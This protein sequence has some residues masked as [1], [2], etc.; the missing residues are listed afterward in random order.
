MA[1]EFESARIGVG[2]FGSE[3]AFAVGGKG[4]AHRHCAAEPDISV[5]FLCHTHPSRARSLFRV[6]PAQVYPSRKCALSFGSRTTSGTHVAPSAACELFDAMHVAA[7]LFFENDQCLKCKQKVGFRADDMTMVTMA[8]ADVAQCRNW[9][10][11]DAC[12]WFVAGVPSG[13]YCISC[14]LNEVVPD[15]ADPQR[16]ALWVET[17]RAKRRLIFTLLELRLPLFGAHDK[18]GLRFRLLA[19]QRVDTGEVEPPKEDPIYIGHDNGCLTLN[20]VEADDAL[21]EAIRKRMGEMY[22]TMLGHLRHEVGHYYWYLLI[23]GMPLLPAFRA[24]FGDETVDYAEALAAHYSSGP[25]DAWQQS[26]VSSYASAH[27]WEDFAETWAHYIH[28]LDTLETASDSA[29][30][31]GGR[32]LTSPLPLAADRPFAA[33]LAEWLRLT[34]CLNELNRSMGLRDAYPFALTDLVIAKLSFVHE[35]CL[36]ATQAAAP[37]AAAAPAKAVRA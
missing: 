29:L 24:V 32:A 34:V 13:D 1:A 37:P 2:G 31:I 30:S 4:H 27:P 18:S 20:V 3:E 33:V 16:R 9:I 14:T 7:R 11:Y 35:L 21:R 28:M 6:E 23:D 15:L 25:S 19:D 12:N 22:R 5:F 36:H 26:F 17:E 10:E 8:A